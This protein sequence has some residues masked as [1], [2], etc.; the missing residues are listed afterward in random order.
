[1]EINMASLGSALKSQQ[2]EDLL[3]E[4]AGVPV[5]REDYEA[6]QTGKVAKFFQQYSVIAFEADHYLALKGRVEALNG[7]ITALSNEVTSIENGLKEQEDQI[8]PFTTQR[9]YYR[10][11]VTHDT[12]ERLAHLRQS[13]FERCSAIYERIIG[14]KGEHNA[15]V[16]EMRP[17]R[18]ELEEFDSCIDDSGISMFENT[19]SMFSH[20]KEVRKIIAEKNIEVTDSQGRVL[21]TLSRLEDQGEA[22]G[23]HGEEAAPYLMHQQGLL[24]HDESKEKGVMARLKSLFSGKKVEFKEQIPSLFIYPKH[25]A[26]GAAK[27]PI[28]HDSQRNAHRNKSLTQKQIR[29]QNFVRAQT[30]AVSGTGDGRGPHL[31]AVDFH[32]SLV[33]AEGGAAA[34]ES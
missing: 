9:E 3:L 24:T 23:L 33:E 1:M 30:G 25:A 2:A 14:L 6:Y 15:L 12:K 17:L 10:T 31:A 32:R 7:E 16:E 20:L 11:D 28:A 19:S 5:N 22:L 4:Q 13:T 34:A 21:Q 8:D 18:Q 26:T 29:E 27:P